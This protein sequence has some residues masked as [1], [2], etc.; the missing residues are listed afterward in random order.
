[1]AS[2]TLAV[3]DAFDDTVELVV[4]VSDF[5]L[6]ALDLEG[7]GVFNA[8]FTELDVMFF[9]PVFFFLALVRSTAPSGGGLRIP[10]D[11]IFFAF[12]TSSDFILD[13]TDLD[14]AVVFVVA[15]LVALPTD[16]TF[17]FPFPFPVAFPFIFPDAFCVDLVAD[18]PVFAFD[19]FFVAVFMVG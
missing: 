7:D 17:A 18:E 2:R 14:E 13:L 8:L 3:L 6:P 12:V 11:L 9:V 4:G 16:L 15:L 10:M 1:M 19:K 5:R